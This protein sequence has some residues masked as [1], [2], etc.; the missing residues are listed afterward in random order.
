[1][2]TPGS[3]PKGTLPN[4]FQSGDAFLESN[5]AGW[6]LAVVLAVGLLIALLFLVRVRRERWKTAGL[7]TA[8]E[9]IFRRLCE[10]NGLSAH[11]VYVLRDMYHDLKLDNPVTPFV[12]PQIYDPYI[13]LLKGNRGPLV[14]AL[15]DQLFAAPP[16][17]ATQRL[18]KRE[19]S[20]QEADSEPSAWRSESSSN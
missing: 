6:M 13:A 11:Q 3:G 8:D 14:A 15:R 18:P 2:S 1:M 20:G 4:L 16:E 5:N 19:E 7:A 10:A 17:H 12:C 9:D